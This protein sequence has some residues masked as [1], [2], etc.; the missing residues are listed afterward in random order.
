MSELQDECDARVWLTGRDVKGR[1]KK[2][3]PKAA[4]MAP[5]PATPVA[6]VTRTPA[7]TLT[8][9]RGSTGRKPGKSKP[10]WDAWFFES[11]ASGSEAV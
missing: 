5:P 1:R 7:A 11:E 2:V 10:E 6:A 9:R 8:A 3:P 4:A